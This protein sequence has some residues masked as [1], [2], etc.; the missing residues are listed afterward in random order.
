MKF[1]RKRIEEHGLS[2]EDLADGLNSVFHGSRSRVFPAKDSKTLLISPGEEYTWKGVLAPHEN[3]SGLV[4]G[5]K[6]HTEDAKKELEKLSEGRPLPHVPHPVEGSD[7]QPGRFSAVES[8]SKLFKD[9]TIP[10]DSALRKGLLPLFAGGAG[11]AAMALGEAQAAIPADQ[12]R[13][14]ADE[15]GWVNPEPPLETPLVS[16]VDLVL[17]P[18]GVA[19]ASGKVAAVAAEPFV[20]WGM[21]VFALKKGKREAAAPRRPAQSERKNRVFSAKRQAVWFETQRVSN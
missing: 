11:A 3:F 15:P 2:P 1:A 16:P 21:S 12:Y 9:S 13:F 8:D 17:A 19:K 4:T 18:A 10:E 7:A 14:P 5:Y 20:A 6:Y